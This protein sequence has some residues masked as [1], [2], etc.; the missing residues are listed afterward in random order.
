MR[1]S[2]VGPI[3]A[4]P[5][6]PAEQPLPST[7]HVGRATLLGTQERDAVARGVHTGAG[8]IDGGIHH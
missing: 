7:E 3:V 8:G 2:A 1:L 5:F 4:M 6:A